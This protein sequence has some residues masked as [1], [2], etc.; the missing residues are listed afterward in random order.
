VTSWIIVG[1]LYALGA[2]FFRLLGGL[3]AAGDAIQRWGRE[4]CGSHGTQESP[5]SSV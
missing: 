3:G 5:S 2:G 4:S 1:V